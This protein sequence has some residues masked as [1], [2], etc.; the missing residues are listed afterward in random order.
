MLKVVYKDLA[1]GVTGNVT[2]VASESQDFVDM[3]QLDEEDL[4]ILNYGTL[5][6]NHWQ[7]KDNVLIL[8]DDLS[9]IDLGYWSESM[10]DENGDFDT[11][12]TITRTYNGTF[13]SSGI[14]IDFD[15]NNEVFASEVNIKWYRGATLLSNKDYTPTSST[16]FFQNNV[17]A[18]DKI[19][20][21]FTKTN[22][23]SRFLRVFHIYDGTIRQFFKDEIVGLE[24][25]ENISD[26]GDEI[27][28][29]TMNLDLIS[30]SPV[31]M[32]FQKVQALSVYNNDT[33]YGTFFVDSSERTLNHYKINC[34]DYVG[35]LDNNTHNGGLYNNVT[36]NAL[37]T[38]LMQDIPFEL[39]NSLKNVL[40]KGY[41]PIDTCRN[42]L[43]QVAFVLGA[44]VDT[45]RTD[46]VLIYP[47][48]QISTAYDLD[49]SKVAFETT[50][51]SEA[52]YTAVTV[53]EH[54]YIR[55]AEA[56]SLYEEVLNGEAFVD[57][58][59]PVSNLSISGGTIV[60]SG[61]NYA[62]IRGTG[63][64]VTLTGYAYDDIAVQKT[65]T[66]PLNTT[67]SIPN[68]FEITDATLVNSSNSATILDRIGTALFNNATIDFSFLLDD[69][70]VGD[71]V[72]IPT[73]EGTKTGQILSIDYQLN[74]NKI[75]CNAT[76]REVI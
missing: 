48:P 47:L 16:F 14:T 1:V 50:E 56:T 74:G 26:V 37:I 7:L 46:K 53:S 13:T 31:K 35:M 57:F 22:V 4:H 67:N 75:M 3:G 44:V 17:V 2:N 49:E 66:N 59:Y 68:V 51:N 61:T 34:Y 55:Q 30:K 32:L 76:L 36:A 72:N 45:S 73:D 21:T 29:N 60:E 39:D 25:L 11:P 19:V 63:S 69:E 9:N 71:F 54:S 18:Y 64:T 23:P 33:L 41:L 65:K 43:M 58:G 42:N 24:I 28:I 12:I 8:P 27:Q 40:I 20:F 5:E 6:G 62:R 10:S 52:P 15:T 70:R 38:E